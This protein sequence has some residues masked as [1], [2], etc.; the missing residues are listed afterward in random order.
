M[1]KSSLAAGLFCLLTVCLL[2][3]PPLQADES[4]GLSSG[5]TIY[6]P[7]YSHIYTGNREKPFL[8][9]VTLS[10]R[11]IDPSGPGLRIS[12]PRNMFDAMSS[13]GDMASDW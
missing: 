6:V 4:L 8:L 1:K 11:N 9:T 3:P 13:A 10:I 2:L 5:Q 12:R 7:A